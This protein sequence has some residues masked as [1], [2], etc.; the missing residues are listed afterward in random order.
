MRNKKHVS[1]LFALSSL[2]VL[3]HL[4][5][6]PSWGFAHSFLFKF[7]YLPIVLSAIWFG[8]WLALQITTL[9]CLVYVFHI[10]IQ[11]YDHAHHH[12][13]TTFLDMGLYFVVAWITGWLSDQQKEVACN[14]REAYEVLK[15]K[16]ALLLEFEKNARKNERLKTMGELA[17]TVAHEVRTPLSALQGAVEIVVSDKSDVQTRKKFSKTIFQEV[18]RINQVVGDFLKLGQEQNLQLE[19]LNLKEFIANGFT[20][21]LPVLKKKNIEFLMDVQ[22]DITVVA[23]KDQFKQVLI[24][25]VMNSVTAI[26]ADKGKVEIKAKQEDGKVVIMIIDDGNGVPVD[27]KNEI[28]RAFVTHSKDGSGL[29]LYLSRNIIRSFEGELCLYKSRPGHTEFRIELPTKV[30]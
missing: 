11:L 9:F 26:T 10:F 13:S 4:F 16:T 7:T 29:G 17:G 30:S 21:L 6:P 1:I 24:N 28:F 20:L 27:L 23:H 22:E 14:L 12:V 19:V 18:Q 3:G 5:S 2:C 15:E 8:R 25:L